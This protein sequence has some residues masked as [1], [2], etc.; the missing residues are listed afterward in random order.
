M[1]RTAP[2]ILAFVCG[3]AAGKPSPTTA[4]PVASI[5]PTVAPDTWTHAELMAHFKAKGVPV[6]YRPV[7]RSFI[8]NQKQSQNPAITII[9]SADDWLLAGSYH[10]RCELHSTEQEAREKSGAD[11]ASWSCG[12]F[13]FTPWWELD[14]SGEQQ[15]DQIAKLLS[16]MLKEKKP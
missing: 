15:F 14:R 8:E 11:P 13:S 16:K 12:R 4:P 9:H 10:V 5:K 1:N 7:G 6:K 2:I 3:C